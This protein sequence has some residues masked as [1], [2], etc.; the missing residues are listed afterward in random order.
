MRAVGRVDAIEV[1]LGHLLGADLAGG[2]EAGE[3]VGG[4]WQS[5]SHDAA[6]QVAR[7]G[8]LV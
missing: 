2:E 5:G 4:L 6:A 3:L 8:V 7:A 1:G